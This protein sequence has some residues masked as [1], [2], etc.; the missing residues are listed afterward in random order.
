MKNASLPKTAATI[1]G[2]TEH[3]FGMTANNHIYGTHHQQNP[4][5]AQ[6]QSS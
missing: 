5:G 3:N 2:K 1:S 6:Q 4:G